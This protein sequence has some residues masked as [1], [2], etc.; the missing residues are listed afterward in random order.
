MSAMYFV[1]TIILAD[2]ICLMCALC[3]NEGA[4][5][6]DSEGQEIETDNVSF[7]KDE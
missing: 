5:N 4:K 1:G 6:A 2:I 7:W 3:R